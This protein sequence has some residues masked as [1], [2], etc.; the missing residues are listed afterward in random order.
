[1]RRFLLAPVAALALLLVAG[2]GPA[3]ADPSADSPNALEHTLVCDNGQTYEIIGGAG[4]SG[5]IVDATGVVIPVAFDFGAGEV[6]IGRGQR[7]GQQ[8][9]L[10]TCAFDGATVTLF[11]AP[12]G[13]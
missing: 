9:V 5:H 12:R 1:M 2:P 11:V 4:A 13:P 6:G 7:T 3:A 10:T 8:E